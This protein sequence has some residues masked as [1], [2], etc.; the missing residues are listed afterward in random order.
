MHA[1]ATMAHDQVE[2]CVA[3]DRHPLPVLALAEHLTRTRV[4]GYGAPVGAL[5]GIDGA[6]IQVHTA[7]E[8]P[9][10]DSDID[11]ELFSSRLEQCTSQLTVRQVFPDWTLVGCYTAGKPDANLLASCASVSSGAAVQLVLDHSAQAFAQVQSA[12]AFPITVYAAADGNLTPVSHTLAIDDAERITL[13]DVSRLARPATSE[14][15][16]GENDGYGRGTLLLTAL[17][18]TESQKKAIEL[19]C[20][21]LDAAIAYVDEVQ[22]GSAPHDHE[23]MRLLAGA[24][25]NGKA[26]HQTEFLA[27]RE[28][29]STDALLTRYCASLTESVNLSSDLVEFGQFAAGGR[30]ARRATARKGI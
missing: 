16:T 7:F 28:R 2:M 19:L 24:V 3:A 18:A 12:G 15:G 26:A 6:P 22:Q 10:R 14:V 13:G 5:L 23:T 29:H 9:M 27:A 4:T 21:R 30:H 8:I 25:A 1:K 17:A 20:S 11:M